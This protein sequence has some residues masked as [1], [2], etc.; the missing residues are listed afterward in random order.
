MLYLGARSARARQRHPGLPQ[1]VLAPGQPGGLE[2]PRQVPGRLCLPVPRLGL[3]YPGQ[4]DQ[5]DRQGKFLYR[6]RCRPGHDRDPDGCL[7][8][9]HIHPPQAAG[10]PDTGRVPGAGLLV[11]EGLPV[12]RT[13]PARMVQRGRESQLEG[14]A[15]R[16]TGRLAR[17]VPAQGQPGPL[18]FRGRHA[19]APQRAGGPWPPRAAGH[20]PSPGIQSHAGGR[21]KPEIRDRRLR[22]VCLYRSAPHGYG[23]I[24]PERRDEP[25]LHLPQR[26]HG[27]DAGLLLDVQRVAACRGPHGM[28]DRREHGPAAQRQRVVLP[29]IQQDRTARYPDGRHRHP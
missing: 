19:V 15:G 10:R 1:Y 14:A 2:K 28:G 3:R 12:C 24:P 9:L 22:C 11:P 6:P 21:G 8:R 18:H 16:A 7:E 13:D 17:A 27:P 20:R 26:H 29:G 5:H 4:A 23:K 25:V